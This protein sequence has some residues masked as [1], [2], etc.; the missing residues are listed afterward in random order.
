M[1]VLILLRR[2]LL[3]LILLLT[4]VL[5][6]VV[7][8][9]RIIV[10][11]LPRITVGVAAVWLI[12]LIV[13]LRIAI[14]RPIVLRP[15]AFCAIG[16]RIVP[17]I[18][19]LRLTVVAGI[20]VGVLRL[21]IWLIVLRQ[22]IGLPARLQILRPDNAN[23]P[24]RRHCLVRFR[25][26]VVVGHRLVANNITLFQPQLRRLELILRKERSRVRAF[27]QQLLIE[28][29]AA[30]G[31]AANF[32]IGQSKIGIDRPQFQHQLA[33]QRHGYFF[34]FRRQETHVRRQVG[35]YFDAVL[36]RLRILQILVVDRAK[37]ITFKLRAGA[38]FVHQERERDRC[39]LA[40]E[41]HFPVQL[42]VA[43]ESIDAA[44]SG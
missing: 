24:L 23:P 37:L 4:A 44:L 29:H 19:L 27:R 28:R 43:V 36:N 5:R 18:L 2:L 25:L 6:L 41:L 34:L 11:L 13:L 39:I 22:R 21:I 20:I 15:L 30:I 40:V 17:L 12:V 16:F 9:L 10:A 33:I 14:L 35:H 31:F 38:G 32:Q 26:F 8:L 7:A 1:I 42:A 3:I